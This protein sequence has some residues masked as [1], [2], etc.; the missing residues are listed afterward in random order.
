MI[1][2]K[3]VREKAGRAIDPLGRQRACPS[4]RH[5]R[6]LL[7]LRVEEVQ[8]GKNSHGGGASENENENG[9]GP[10][11]P[12]LLLSVG[13]CHFP[14]DRT[15]VFDPSLGVNRG[16]RG[17]VVVGENANGDEKEESGRG[18]CGRRTK[19]GESGIGAG[20]SRTFAG[21]TGVVGYGMVLGW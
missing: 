4:L 13:H 1:A 3:V 20:D 15:V 18:C 12:S 7:L 14:V 6:A 11:R 2:E 17:L 21:G 16:S 19:G 5:R 10:C 9:V 8:P